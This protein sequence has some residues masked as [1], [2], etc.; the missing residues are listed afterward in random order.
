MISKHSF[1]RVLKEE[2]KHHLFLVVMV[3]AALLLNLVSFYFEIQNMISYRYGESEMEVLISR[4]V[5][6]RMGEMVL[7]S[8]IGIVM[9]VEY[10]QYLHSRRQSDFFFSLPI[11]R[12]KKY[13][14]GVTVCTILFVIFDFAGCATK[15]LIL[16]TTGCTG[17]TVLYNLFWQFICMMIVYF[18]NWS[19]MTLAMVISG[20][21][22]VAVCSFSVMNLYVPY[23]I[24][25][26]IPTFEKIFYVTYAEVSKSSEVWNYFSPLALMH[27]IVGNE[28]TWMFENHAASLLM[29]VI[30]GIVIFY[31]SLILY[32]KRPTEAAEHA[33]AFVKWNPVINLLCSVPFG[34]WCGYFVYEMASMNRMFW[35]V[36][37][38]CFGVLLVHGSMECIFEFDLRVMFKKKRQFIIFLGI[39]L[40]FLGVMYLNTGKYNSYVASENDIEEIEVNLNCGVVDF[41]KNSSESWNVNEELKGI[42]GKAIRPVVAFVGN[43][44]E[45]QSYDE[46]NMIEKENREDAGEITVEYKLKNGRRAARCYRFDKEDE[47]NIALLDMIVGNREFKDDFYALYS[48]KTSDIKSIYL[49]NGYETVLLDLD[50]SEMNEFINAYLNDLAELT[51][52]EMK[53][54]QRIGKLYINTSEISDMELCIYSNFKSTKD[55]LEKCDAENNIL[56]INEELLQLEVYNSDETKIEIVIEDEKILERLKKDVLLD[57]FFSADEYVYGIENARVVYA[58]V[59]TNGEVETFLSW[60]R[61]DALNE[62]KR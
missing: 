23:I 15:G 21:T 34:L 13:L 33:F 55:C 39:S 38:T 4:M 46:G 50:A 3:F 7:A 36:V 1:V 10:F 43:L 62:I 24:K 60:I 58:K 41:Y 20:N 61:N 8:V 59:K 53:N 22:I 16:E 5:Q 28:S 30:L 17:N 40:I 19:M 35:L 51:Y 42:R 25:T 45:K 11:V 56:K 27:G 47:T 26:L 52:T 9:A 54:E 31:V 14:T 49:A 18:A 48:L 2:V 37:G 29:L 57:F 6:P 12:K 32:D 44:I